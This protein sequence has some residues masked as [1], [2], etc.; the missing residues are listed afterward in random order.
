MTN[1]ETV[2]QSIHLS[3][4]MVMVLE[5][6]CYLANQPAFAPVLSETIVIKDK[7]T[8]GMLKDDSEVAWHDCSLHFP[9]INIAC[10]FK[11]QNKYCTLF[12]M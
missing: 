11:R 12:K 7:S 2:P 10:V 9:K 6:W 5:P 8:D 3:T 1:N 4:N